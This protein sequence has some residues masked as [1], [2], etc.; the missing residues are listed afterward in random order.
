MEDIEG[1]RLSSAELAPSPNGAKPLFFNKSSTDFFPSPALASR[2]M[3]AM[4][5][6]WADRI[7]MYTIFQIGIISAPCGISPSSQTA[8]LH[9][10]SSQTALLHIPSSQTALPH[11]TICRG[12]LPQGGPLFSGTAAL[13]GKGKSINRF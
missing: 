4:T 10:P 3:A 12:L 1:K 2:G 7:F 5:I 8:L 9:I 11:H 6:L 13:W